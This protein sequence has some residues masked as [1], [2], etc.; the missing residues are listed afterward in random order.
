MF[1][2]TNHVFNV[3]VSAYSGDKSTNVR[4]IGE[5]KFFAASVDEQRIRELADI[6]RDVKDTIEEKRQEAAGVNAQLAE[7]KNVVE[8]IKSRKKT[9]ATKAEERNRINCNLRRAQSQVDGIK[10]TL[11]DPAAIYADADKLREVK[12]WPNFFF[13]FFFFYLFNF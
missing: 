8:E 6:E 13:F 1:Y 3:R 5:P 12:T 7:L 2:S 9:L 10:R 11:R 4:T